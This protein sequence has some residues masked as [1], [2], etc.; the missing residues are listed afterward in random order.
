MFEVLA[1]VYDHYWHSDA[2]PQFPA[3]KRKLNDVGFDDDEIV[4]ALVWLEDLK[5]AARVLPIAPHA[6]PPSSPIA[7][8]AASPRSMRVL[9]RQEQAR[10]GPVGWGFVLFLIQCGALS[11]ERLELVMDRA[12]A[13]PGQPMALDDLKLVI[14]MV[15]WSLGE[16]PDALV[17]DEL[18]D[19]PNHR[20]AN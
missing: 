12:M 5:S 11:P 17:L 14:L 2:C 19:H 8:A 13:A 10:L 18:C 7:P 1:F 16:E 4:N 6:H 3:L 20:L 15:F 9:T